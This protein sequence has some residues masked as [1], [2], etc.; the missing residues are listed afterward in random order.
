MRLSRE[1]VLRIAAL[2]KIRMTEEEI[3]RFQEQ[4]SD[5][6]DN[7]EV[8]KQVDTENIEPT[9][10]PNALRNVVKQDCAGPSL[11]PDE[12]L[13]NAPRR[14]GEFFRIRAVLEED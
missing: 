5:I 14:E 3:S 4:L 6:L 12:V 9:A 8:L 11:S 2:A 1:E 10:Q 13:A 7:F